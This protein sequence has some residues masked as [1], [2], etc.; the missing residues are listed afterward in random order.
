MMSTIIVTRK[1]ILC[2]QF[3]LFAKN[4]ILS[5]TKF[6]FSDKSAIIFNVRQKMKFCHQQNF[7]SAINQRKHSLIIDYQ[8]NDVL[9]QCSDIPTCGISGILPRMRFLQ[10][11]GFIKSQ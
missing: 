11:S 2:G 3:G 4:E 7:N 1:G 9:G 8:S 6:H 5:S 10:S